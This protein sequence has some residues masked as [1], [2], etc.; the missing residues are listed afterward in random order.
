VDRY[1]ST[2]EPDQFQALLAGLDFE[3]LVAAAPEG[4]RSS[5]EAL[6]DQRQQVLDALANAP[7]PDSIPADALP[8]TFVDALQHLFAVAVQECGF[9]G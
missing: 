6:R 2:I 5:I 9:G 3:A 7:S 1:G 4:F 8:L